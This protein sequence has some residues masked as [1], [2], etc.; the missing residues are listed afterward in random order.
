MNRRDLALGGAYVGLAAG[1]VGVANAEAGQVAAAA[2]AGVMLGL[3]AV[4]V[5]VWAVA[6][7]YASDGSW[8][9]DVPEDGAK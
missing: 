9:K 2:L 3:P 6:T 7:Y 5:A 8:F 4:V 1:T